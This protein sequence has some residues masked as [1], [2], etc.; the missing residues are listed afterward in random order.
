M[1]T[2]TQLEANRA[3]ARRSTGPKT[4]SGKARSSMNA[5][6]HGL[7]AKEIVIWDED[8]AEFEA[9]CAGLTADF[10]PQTTFEREL[11]DRLAGLLWRLRRV[12][13][14][15]ACIIK[16]PAH[17]P[18]D[19]RTLE[20]LTVEE[21]DQLTKISRKLIEMSNTPAPAKGDTDTEMLAK[22]SRHETS[23]ANMVT[24]TLSLL[25][26]I[27]ASQ[28]SSEKTVGGL[29]TLLRLKRSEGTPQATAVS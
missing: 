22:I 7:T 28:T 12:P 17:K 6:K 18:L 3:N 19:E 23:L 14:L 5:C 11:V 10:A 25:H 8:P 2:K 20:K 9:L 15:E 4:P 21:L 13:V 1:A 27:Q 24:K 26:A 16:P 29:S